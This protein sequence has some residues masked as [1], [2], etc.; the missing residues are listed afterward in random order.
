MQS[1]E[2]MKLSFFVLVLICHMG[3]SVLSAQKSPSKIGSQAP[4]FKLAPILNFEKSDAKLS[5]F[6]GKVVVLDFWATWCTPCV[7][8]IPHLDKLQKKFKNELQI[9]L[10]ANS[11]NEKRL[12]RFLTKF[13]T[14]LPIVV[15]SLNT[16]KKEYP[17]RVISHTVVIGKDGLVKAVTTPENLSVALIE[18][19]VEGHPVDIVEKRDVFGFDY[20]APLPDENLK[21]KFKLT[22]YIE[23]AASSVSSIHN[24]RVLITNN[25]LRGLYG[26]AY[27]NEGPPFR[28]LNR[29]R[30]LLNGEY[31]SVLD[32]EN[33][34]TGVYHKFDISNHDNAYCLEIVAPEMTDHEIRQN[35]IA[36]L[37]Q[38]FSLKSRLERIRT[39]VKVLRRTKEPLMLPR[40][41]RN[42]VPSGG[43]S[44]RGIEAKN[45]SLAYIA[46]YIDNFGIFDVPVIDG[47]EL[48]GLYDIKIAYF[49]ENPSLFFDE[50]KDLGLVLKDA[51]REVEM[52]IL[53]E[54]NDDEG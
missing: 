32:I 27:A 16:L 21:F 5:E 51:E 18:K 1:F 50:L 44:G 39:K 4:N 33:D 45:R 7:K 2:Y 54:N 28:S 46:E 43:A 42:T 20:K 47:T 26:Y 11:D 31:H 6:R 22:G 36:F 3:G 23:A 49:E 38:N 30:Y 41:N 9:F 15:D 29:T 13:D 14:N 40:S 48:D 19:L 52:L 12:V 35:M 37:H 10:V 34:T 53:Y 8:A 17:H 25:S 24:G